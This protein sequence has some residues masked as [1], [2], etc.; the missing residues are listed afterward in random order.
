[1]RANYF[2]KK[3]I[4]KQRTAATTRNLSGSRWLVN[5]DFARVFKGV[6]HEFELPISRIGRDFS[7]FILLRALSGSFDMYA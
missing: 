1:M 2:S 7:S 3:E 4:E 6:L 5:R